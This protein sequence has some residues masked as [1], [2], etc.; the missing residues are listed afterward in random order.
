MN[1][2]PPCTCPVC[3]WCDTPEER[4]AQSEKQVLRDVDTSVLASRAHLNSELLVGQYEDRRRRQQQKQSR[5]E[6]RARKL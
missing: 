4:R 1:E 3:A 2:Y 6:G 5:R